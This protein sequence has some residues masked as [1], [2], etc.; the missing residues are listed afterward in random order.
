M[1][2][3]RARGERLTS[4]A[5]LRFG[6]AARQWLDGPVVNLRPATRDCYRNALEQHLLKRLA[7]RR[8]DSIRPDELADLVRDLRGEGLP[9]S[10]IVIVIGVVNRVYRF[11]A[12][13]LGWS[14]QNPVSL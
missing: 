1:L 6:D 10:S 7:T 8:L 11:A 5:R 12:R 13:R 2:A 9:D 4:N 14:G 3:R